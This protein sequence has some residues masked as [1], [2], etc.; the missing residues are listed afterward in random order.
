MILGEVADVAVAISASSEEGIAMQHHLEEVS[1]ELQSLFEIEVLH[2]PGVTTRQMF[3]YPSYQ[4]KDRLFAFLVAGDVVLTQLRSADRESLARHHAIQKFKTGER[5]LKYW[6]RITVKDKR[7]L[8][9]VM[10]FVRK[11]YEITLAR[12][13]DK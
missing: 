9:V 2:W 12:A 10:P 13:L 4:V 6:V 3:G 1:Q 5:E 11:S 8:G 7:D